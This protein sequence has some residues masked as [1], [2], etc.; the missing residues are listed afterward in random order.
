MNDYTGAFEKVAGRS[1]YEMALKADK[2]ILAGTRNSTLG[3]MLRK[4][5]GSV[6]KR[7]RQLIEKLE[8]RGQQQSD[9]AYNRVARL[10]GTIPKNFPDSVPAG[11][12]AGFERGKQ[13]LRDGFTTKDLKPLRAKNV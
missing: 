13:L 1:K 11:M 9:A 5:T 12:D 6:T 4:N 10:Y 8:R 7:E 3:E 2:S